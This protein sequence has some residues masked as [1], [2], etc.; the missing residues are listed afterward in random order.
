MK[1]MYNN[2]NKG[3]QTMFKFSFENYKSLANNFCPHPK[4]QSYNIIICDAFC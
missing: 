4:E 3:M 1:S 2:G